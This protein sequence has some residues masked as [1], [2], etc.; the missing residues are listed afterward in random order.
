MNSLTVRIAWYPAATALLLLLLLLLQLR[1]R[2]RW[3][4]MSWVV[5]HRSAG[6]LYDTGT[7]SRGCSGI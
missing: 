5:V 3:S 7:A 4:A 6:A 2:P 1:V